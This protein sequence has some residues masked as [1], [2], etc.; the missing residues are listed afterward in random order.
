M[1][2]QRKHLSAGPLLNKIRNSF[3][4]ISDQV[5]G[6]RK[7]PITLADCLMSAMAV[8]GLKYPSLLQFEEEN[9]SETPVNQNIKKLYKVTN[10][11][12]D[13]Y[14]RER[15]DEVDPSDIRTPFKK[16]FAELQRGN[17][18]ESFQFIDGAYLLSIDGTEFFSSNNVYCE[19]CCVKNHKDGTKTYYKQM[20]CGAIV[21]PKLK[22]VI[23]L[24]PEPIRNTDGSAKND[25]EFNAAKRFLE[26]CRREHPHLK[27]IITA[28]S[29]LSKAPIIKQ[30]RSLKFNYIITAKPSDHQYL[31][32]FV[33]PILKKYSFKSADGTLREYYYTNSVPI[34][35][36]NL[37]VEVNF[38][39]YV[40]TKPK[41]KRLRF[42]WITDIAITDGNVHQIM[43]GGRARWRIENETFNTLKNQGYHFEHNYGHGNKNLST[44]FAMLMMLGFMVDQVQEMSDGAF[45]KALEK[46]IRKKYFWEWLRSLFTS[47]VIDSWED[48]WH[49]LGNE[50]K[51]VN[52][53]V[54]QN[55]T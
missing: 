38:L 33:R 12:S 11:P 29:L 44:V 8:F 40:E 4:E 37:D 51:G 20:L 48:L 50:I 34:N 17:E 21:H 53:S 30:I 55:S 7:D 23:P 22:T 26:D 25:C 31:F 46:R 18:L 41:G 24:A 47:Y 16:I 27:L 43:Q 42:S 36:S 9:N 49:V 10:V 6:S 14:M 5:K 15:L 2:K 32:D 45:Q 3:L 13:T 35:G 52:L 28:D 1:S 39:E 19:N 54:L